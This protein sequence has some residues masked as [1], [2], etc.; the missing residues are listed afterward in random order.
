VT[1]TV[2][3]DVL[4]LLSE[5]RAVEG[6]G[7]RHYGAL[8]E[9]APEWM[10]PRLLEYAEQARRHALVIETAVE[11]LGGDPSYASASAREVTRLS[12]ETAALAAG[13][14]SHPPMNRLLWL[15]GHEDRDLLIWQ[16]IDALAH[17]ERGE[18]GE[19]LR[20][21]AGAVLTQETAG[22]RGADR[23]VE[24][25][26]WLRDIIRRVLAAEYGL[27]DPASRTGRRFGRR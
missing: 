26:E 18:A 24:R 6:E 20:T 9:E 19:V 13:T 21:A 10:R 22:A 17:R 11:R 23:N 12:E 7:A 16:L 27:A 5:L 15:L 14:P 8:A 2:G 25:Q 1:A 3:Q 4:D